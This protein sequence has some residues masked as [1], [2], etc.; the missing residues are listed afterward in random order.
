[1]N[2]HERRA[3]KV[4]A[5]LAAKNSD[6]HIVAVHEA[7]HAVAKVLAAGELSY[8]IDEA[9]D[10]I[11]MGMADSL[12]RSGDGR[13]ITIS[14]GVTFG[15]M[16]SPDILEASREFKQTYFSERGHP[17]QVILEGQ[18]QIEYL[19]KFVELGRTAGADIGKWFRARVFDA[20]SGSMAE[21]IFSKRAFYDVWHGYEAESDEFSV[22]RDAEWAGIGVDEIKSTIRRMAVLSFCLMEKPKVWEAVLALAN[23][24]PAV[25]TMKG[26]TAVATIAG[27]IPETNLTGMFGEALERVSELEREI[28]AAKVVIVETPDGLKDLTKGKELLQNVKDGDTEVEVLT[29]Q[30]TLPVFGEV[31]F[32]AFGDGAVSR[33]DAKAA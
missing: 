28:S 9:I 8:G 32:H 21:A 23:K 15:P 20:V 3:A 5:R 29:Y 25:G 11:E 17:K 7:G 27:V 13:M 18:E 24:L 26:V 14:Q 31:L 33:E 4:R 12:G 19:S 16:F 6:L 2:R 30:S 1:M 10:R 22:V